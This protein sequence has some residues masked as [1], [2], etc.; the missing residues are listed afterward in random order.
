MH[1][2]QILYEGCRGARPRRHNVFNPL[3]LTVGLRQTKTDE[4]PVRIEGT[5]EIDGVKELFVADEVHVE[6]LHGA[7]FDDAFA[8]E[9]AH[10]INHT[11][12]AHE[13]SIVGDLFVALDDFAGGEW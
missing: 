3:F 11:H 10:E 2:P 1:R 7:F 9:V 12:L 8:H 5:G 13:T 6:A 4:I